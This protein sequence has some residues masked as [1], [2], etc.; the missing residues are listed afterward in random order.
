MLRRAAVAAAVAVVVAFGALAVVVTLAAPATARADTS[1]LAREGVTVEPRA[2]LRGKD[3]LC[4][5]YPLVA[6]LDWALRFYWLAMQDQFDEPEEMDGKRDAITDLYTRHG[7]FLGTFNEEFAWHLRMEGSGRLLD[8]RVINYTGKCKYGY[9]TCFEELDHD[10]HPY[11]RGA[12]QR[13]LVPFKSVAVDPRFIPIGETLYIPEFDGM[14]LPDG[15]V[16]DGCVRADDTGGGIKKHKMDFFVVS[17]ANFRFLLDE[18][19]GVIWI[20][21]TIEDPRC[22]YLRDP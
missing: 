19:W 18:L 12:G 6:E 11:G 10:T 13:A 7:L 3:K 14:R 4:C 8:G 9:G 22:D 16:H 5:G 17:Y 21:P 2:A 1:K 15:S 20:T